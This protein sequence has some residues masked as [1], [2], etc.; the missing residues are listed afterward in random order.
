MPGDTPDLSARPDFVTH[1]VENQPPELSPYDA[2]A[3]DAPLREAITREGGGW[4]AADIARYGALVGGD[5]MELG[6]L[7]NGNKPQ[8]KPFDRFGNRIDEVEFHPA[9]HRLMALGVEHGVTGFAWRNAHTPGAHVARMAL[10]YLHNQAEQG[11]SC[12]LTMTYACVPA[13]RHQPELAAQWLPRI[14][15]NAYDPRSVPAAAKPGNTIGMGMTEKQGGSDVRANTT[16]ATRIGAAGSA[17]NYRVVGHKWFYSAPMCDAHLVLANTAAGLS[18]FLIPRWLPDGTRNAVRLQRLKDK[19]GDWSNA[20]AEV[21]FQNALAWPVGDD[22]RGVATILEMVALT[23]QDCMI[24]SASIMRQAL[25]QAIHHTRHRRAFGKPLS[26]QPL[27]RNVLAD[28]ALESEAHTVLTARVA[29]AVDASPRDPQEAA[30]ARIATAIGKYWVCKRTTPFVNEAQECLGGNG[31]IEESNLARLYR[32]APLNSIWEG[33]GNIQCLDV[34]RALAREPASRDALFA[35][36]G[37]AKGG[38][39]ALDA[40][41]TRLTHDLGNPADLELSSRLVTERLALALQASLLV[42]A[43]NHPVADAFCVTRIERAHGQAF[44]TLPA[45]TAMAALIT[46]AFP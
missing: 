23:R 5:M 18:C 6:R 9:Y 28:L 2:W 12:P 14:V 36:L 20:S 1:A 27:M 37:V 34:L 30:F 17:P 24:G 41:V 46:R 33:S 38:N 31:Y 43:G 4:A 16:R 7:A 32:Q 44:G 13:L 29:R 35:E 42:R 25:V 21:E 8:F 40:E 22:G 10:S 15:S 3:T 45:H 19:L 39:A 11:T 26:E